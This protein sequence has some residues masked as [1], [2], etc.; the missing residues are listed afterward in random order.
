MSRKVINFKTVI[1]FLMNDEMMKSAT[2]VG[3][4]NSLI[5]KYNKNPN[6]KFMLNYVYAKNKR[7]YCHLRRWL[8]CQFIGTEM[9]G[10]YK[11][12]FVKAESCVKISLREH[13]SASG[14]YGKINGIYK[15]AE[16]Y[17]IFYHLIDSEVFD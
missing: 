12:K 17:F 1:N 8:T 5:Q 7:L 10:I 3:E 14:V 11:R 15:K 4:F 16:E 13:L 9:E 6:K 2:W